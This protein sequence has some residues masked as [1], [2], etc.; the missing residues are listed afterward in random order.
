MSIHE[1]YENVASFVKV[2]CKITLHGISGVR[3]VQAHFVAGKTDRT[4]TGTGD[5]TVHAVKS[6]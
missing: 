1:L 6:V 5:D 2:F 4:L 3:H